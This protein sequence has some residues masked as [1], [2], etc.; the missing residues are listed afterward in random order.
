MSLQSFY[1]VYQAQG[2]LSD[3]TS[4]QPFTLLDSS[5]FLLLFVYVGQS[6]DRHD[7]ITPPPQGH[8][9]LLHPT[10]LKIPNML[11]ASI[12]NEKWHGTVCFVLLGMPHWYGLRW[13]TLGNKGFNSLILG[14]YSLI[15]FLPT[16]HYH[17]FFLSFLSH[18]HMLL[19][20]P[21]Q[22]SMGEGIN[23]LL[24]LPLWLGVTILPSSKASST[25]QSRWLTPSS[26]KREC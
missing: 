19:E 22:C 3:I 24:L 25:V 17:I 1:R 26:C 12:I 7:N 8:C 2:T 6:R 9:T 16:E 20:Y 23:S 15:Y 14:V 18:S 11:R 21:T 5:K 13:A 10:G 4:I